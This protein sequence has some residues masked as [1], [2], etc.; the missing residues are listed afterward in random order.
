ML[1]V[2]AIE[3]ELMGSTIIDK[4]SFQL[5][6]GECV[7]LVGPSG[8]GKTTILRA[9]AALQALKHGKIEHDFQTLAFLFQEPRLL[10]WRSALENV[11]LVAPQAKEKIPKLL[12]Q[13]GFIKTDFN[14]YPHE[15]SGGMR[16][17]IALARALII[18]PDLLLMDEPFSALD[19]QLRR[20]LQQ[21]LI[22]KISAGM[23]VCLVTHDRDEAVL[24]GQRILRL[25][26]KPAHLA[27]VLTL[28]TPYCQRDEAWIRQQVQSP[29]FM[30]IQQVESIL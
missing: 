25:E 28:D 7:C 20:Q 4:V 9:I 24:L 22:E 13:L 1:S 21:L 12:Q 18:E 3:I 14:K 19:H 26:G 30:Q 27:Q 5:Q 16:Q 6:R 15:L 10:A 8:C 11:A 17:R 23:A 29:F 2:N